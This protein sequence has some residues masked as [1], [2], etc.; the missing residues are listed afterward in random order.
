MGRLSILGFACFVAGVVSATSALAACPGEKDDGKRL[1]VRGTL[2][3]AEKE[4]GGYGFG[5]KECWIYIEAKGNDGGACKVGKKITA[6]GKFSSCEAN[7]W[8]CDPDLGDPDYLES[9]K[10]S[11]K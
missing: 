2:E 4:D 10:V 5:I 7:I 11:C 6:T 1:T 8:D 9:A 3:Y